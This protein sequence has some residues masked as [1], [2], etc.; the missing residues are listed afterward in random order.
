MQVL[1]HA[2]TGLVYWENIRNFDKKSTVISLK[3]VRVR[4][5]MLLWKLL[6]SRS[7]SDTACTNDSSEARFSKAPETFQ[8]C[9]PILVHLRLKTEK[10]I[11][12]K[13]LV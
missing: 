8:A 2:T 5:I 12:L 7:S 10:C 4:D 9:K 1:C 6:T 3:E 11:R 13:L